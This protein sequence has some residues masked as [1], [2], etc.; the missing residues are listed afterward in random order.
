MTSATVLAGCV[1]SDSDDQQGLTY[2]DVPVAYVTRVTPRDDNGDPLPLELRN[3]DSFYPG[4]SLVIRDAAS[5]SAP[6]VNVTSSLFDGAI[7]IKDLHISADGQQLL[8]ALRAPEDPD[9]DDDEQPTWNIWRYSVRSKVASRV[10]PS[11]IVAE[12][13]QDISPAFLP[14]GRI[15]FASTRQT[16]TQARLLDESKQ[17]FVP[18]EEERDA[19]AFA[20]HVMTPDGAD[21]EQISFNA[22]HDLWPLALPG[23]ELLYIRWDGKGRRDELNVYRLRPD[24]TAVSIL[25]GADSHDTVADASAWTQPRLLDDGRLLVMVRDPESERWD[26]VPM[27]IDFR[28]YINRN[29]S[30][31]G[32]GG[33]AEQSLLLPA[34]AAEAGLSAFGR[35][36]A[37]TPL[38]DGSGRLLA[39]WSPCRLR[40]GAGQLLPC[41]DPWLNEAVSEGAP[42]FGLWV[43]DPGSGTRR[44]VVPGRAGRIISDVLVLGGRRIE[45]VLA[46]ATPG[47]ELDQSLYDEGAGVLDIRSVYD[48]AGTFNPLVTPPPGV[49]TLAEYADPALVTA[50]DRRVLF[51]RVLKGVHIPDDDVREIDNDDIGVVPDLGMRELV[52]YAPVAPD[53][54]VRVTVPANVPLDI[55]LVDSQARSVFAEHGSWITVRPGET[56]SC[57]GCH[58]PDSPVVHGRPEAEPANINAGA[59]VTGL[60]FPNTRP[61]LFADAGD[62]MAQVLS[63]LEPDSQLPSVDLSYTDSWTDPNVR[64]VDPDWTVPYADLDTPSPADAACVTAWQPLCAT[65]INYAD[66]IQPLWEL[67]RAAGLGDACTGCH[68]NRDAMNAL[69]VAAGNLSLSGDVSPESQDQLVSYRELLIDDNEQELVDGALVDRLV[70]LLDEGGNIVYQTDADGNLVLDINDQPIPVEVTV[71]V[72]ASMVPGSALASRFFSVFAVGQSHEGMLTDAEQRL[73][74]EWLDMGAQNYNNPFDVPQ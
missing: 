61:A 69:R 1:G 40:D 12:E 30:L 26:G 27:A 31:S 18:L 37:V 19:P 51:L 45:R 44:P 42:A 46:D 29:Q 68:S 22:S 60:P 7:D 23:G 56:F 71:P 21:I 5:P 9:L 62:T 55:Q 25:Y 24:G 11:D 64:P 72:T 32:P 59:P 57:G 36:A 34:A 38:A 66:H 70:P 14:D 6:E 33:R 65:V 49:T 53:G 35:M 41:A 4:A 67:P 73:L 58:E 15:V 74:H 54:S 3:P 43:F 48:F 28:D 17:P 13:G 20:L 63:R 16:Q 10:I 47:V 39:A 8:F 2:G 52:G 50:D